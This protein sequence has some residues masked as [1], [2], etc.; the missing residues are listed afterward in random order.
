MSTS[1]LH[2]AVRGIAAA[3]GQ[4]RAGTRIG[5]VSAYD[6][7]RYAVKVKFPP[8]DV[9]TGWIPLQAVQVGN[10][11]GIYAP[12]NIDDQIKVE[13]Q[14]GA[15][16]AGLAGGA[17]FN[18]I[19]VPLAVPP[20]EVWI[21]HQSGA[22]WK[23]SNDGKA[24]FADGHGAVVALNGDGTISSQGN[25]THNGNMAFNGQVVAN[26]HRIDETHKHLNSGGSGLGGV[27]Q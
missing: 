11:F 14:D 22:S 9:E 5:L 19:D 17:L 21:V 8:D 13:F 10:G 16:D 24:T 3:A 15:Q 23:L 1:R 7:S 20:G 27:V 2:N 25:W 6:P 4:G 26:G 18:D 12:P